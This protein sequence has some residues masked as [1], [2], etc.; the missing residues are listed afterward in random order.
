MFKLYH[1]PICPLSRQVRVILKEL[2]VPF[3]LQKEEYWQ[4]RSA[5]L[6][7][8]PAGEVPVVVADSINIVGI[9]PIIEYLNE[10]FPSSG[11]MTHDLYGKCEVRRMLSWANEKFYRE[12]TKVIIDEKIMKLFCSGQPPRMDYIR[13]A[14]ANLA[15]HLNYFSKLLEA[16]SFIVGEHLTYADIAVSSQI[17]VIDYFGEFNWDTYPLLRNWYAIMKSRPSFRP[18]LQE[19]IPG[20]EPSV[21]YADLDF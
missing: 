20:Y 14:K 9:Y 18:V 2:G 7:I 6:E 4:R 8:N 19:I 17:S 16:H 3:E 15:K 21:T 1:Y 13:I 11:F 10:Q 5:F 12:T